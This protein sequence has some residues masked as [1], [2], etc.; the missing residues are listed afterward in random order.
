M[1]AES[2]FVLVLV[3]CLGVG[4]VAAVIGVFFFNGFH[5]WDKL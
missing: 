3:L 4:L 5:W 1:D 2:I